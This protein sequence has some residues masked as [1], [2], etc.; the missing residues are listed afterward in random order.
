[1]N[2]Q[3]F[4]VSKS[5]RFLLSEKFI[6][7]DASY[8]HSLSFISA[9]E[10]DTGQ[11]MRVVFEKGEHCS[12]EQSFKLL[13]YLDED[14]NLSPLANQTTHIEVI[15][16]TRP[17]PLLS[18]SP[19]SSGSSS[20]V[21]SLIIALAVLGSVV[22]IL[23]LILIVL[24]LLKPANKVRQAENFPDPRILSTRNILQIRNLQ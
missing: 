5:S 11:Y 21:P 24:L 8:Q 9:E 22:L 3:V 20:P 7:E 18:P 6:L 23:L 19:P 10:V 17:S 1:M 12:K 14:S 15:S 2:F 13:I 4:K 16:P